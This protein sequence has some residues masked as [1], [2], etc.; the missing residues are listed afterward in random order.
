MNGGVQGEPICEGV[1]MTRQ[2]MWLISH[3]EESYMPYIGIVVMEKALDLESRVRLNLDSETCW[4][5]ILCELF[6]LGI[7]FLNFKLEIIITSFSWNIY[8][9]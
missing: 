3:G 9:D 7:H 2:E 1:E 5:M 8:E 6:S 4:S